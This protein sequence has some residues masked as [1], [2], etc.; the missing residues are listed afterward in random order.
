MRRSGRRC[1]KEAKATKDGAIAQAKLESQKQGS[2][3]SGG[4]ASTGQSAAPAE[5]QKAKTQ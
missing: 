4:S 1:E 3:S 5:P 2:A